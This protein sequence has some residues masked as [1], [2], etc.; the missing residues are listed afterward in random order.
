M[1]LLAPGFGGA[2]AGRGGEARQAAQQARILRVEAA[3]LRSADPGHAGGAAIDAERRRQHF[4]GRRRKGGAGTAQQQRLA[5]RR[6]P[7]DAVD[8]RRRHGD[9]RRAGPAQLAQQLAQALR[10]V[11]RPAPQFLRERDQRPV[12]AR[13]VRSARGAIRQFLRRQ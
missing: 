1:A 13:V 10:H 11:L 4:A 2:A 5:A 12:F 8:L 6:G 9:A 3:G 7:V